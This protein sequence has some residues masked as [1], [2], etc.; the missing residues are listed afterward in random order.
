MFRSFAAKRF[1]KIGARQNRSHISYD[2]FQDNC[3]D[4]GGELPKRCQ[5]RFG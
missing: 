3:C 1:Q 2:G 4:L 5:D